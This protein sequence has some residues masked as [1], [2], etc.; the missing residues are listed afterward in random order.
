[1]RSDFV[2]RVLSR[3][4]RGGKS[5]RRRSC[6]SACR[7]AEV[8]PGTRA[9]GDH[10]N[11]A[12]HLDL[13]LP[14]VCS[15]VVSTLFSSGQKNWANRCRSRI[16]CRPKTAA[17]RNRHKRMSPRAF[18]VEGPSPAARCRADGAPC[19]AQASARCATPLRFSAGHIRYCSIWNHRDVIPFPSTHSYAL[20]EA[21]SLN[22]SVRPLG[23]SM[24]TQSTRS[25]FPTPKITGS[26]DCER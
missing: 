13:V 20:L 23:Q 1:M 19:T 4:T 22:S 2:I 17:G 24:T 5:G 15:V 26:S 6:S 9:P 12:V 25:R 16:S 3:Y 21:T 8:H 14:C 18:R 7:S 11:F 10:R